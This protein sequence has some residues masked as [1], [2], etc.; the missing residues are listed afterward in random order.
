MSGV[1]GDSVAPNRHVIVQEVAM[2]QPRKYANRAAQQAAYRDRQARERELLLASKGLP[3][4]PAISS[5]PGTARW[6]GML[7]H[8]QTLLTH[9]VDEMQDYHDDRSEEW[10]ESCKAETLLERMEV[11]QMAADAVAELL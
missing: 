11:I 2:P 10:Q 8:A 6:K 5:M 4:L 7:L 9:A 3:V 1:G